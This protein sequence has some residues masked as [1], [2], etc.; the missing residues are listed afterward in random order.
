MRP[1]DSGK[2][3]VALLRLKDGAE[4]MFDLHTQTV[5]TK[6][7]EHGPQRIVAQYWLGG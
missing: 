3:E 6:R 2:N 1:V 4:I 5:I 7:E